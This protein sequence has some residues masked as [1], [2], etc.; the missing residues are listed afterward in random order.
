MKGYMEKHAM[1][2]SIAC[3]LFC[4]VLLAF[5]CSDTTSISIKAAV[6]EPVI[7]TYS[8]E[9][10]GDVYEIPDNSI[11]ADEMKAKGEAN[12]REVFIE[13][14]EYEDIDKELIT[15]VGIT[16]DEFKWIC[17]VAQVEVRGA[18]DSAVA[19]VVNVI[20]NRVKSDEFKQDNIIGI[21]KAKGQFVYTNRVTRSMQVSVMKAL[22]REDTT[23]GALFFCT[24]KKCGRG[25]TRQYIRTDEV[26]HHL[27]K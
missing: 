19:N 21:C 4:V 15:S 14:L 13:Q 26:G 12:A 1:C 20:L 18:P 6:K 8:V 25:K 24:C 23:D 11:L 22:L 16:E 10:S 27:W 3:L 17:R 9:A 2:L 7:V 5:I